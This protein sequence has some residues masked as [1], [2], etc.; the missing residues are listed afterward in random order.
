MFVFDIPDASKNAYERII[1]SEYSKIDDF[2]KLKILDYHGFAMDGTTARVLFKSQILRQE[3]E[4]KLN[5]RIP[6]ENELHSKLDMDLE[7]FNPEYYY[8][9][10]SVLER[11]Q[12]NVKST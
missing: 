2:M 10:K 4:E 3:L 11:K 7:I 5:C 8:T 1:N 6:D 12:F 9:A